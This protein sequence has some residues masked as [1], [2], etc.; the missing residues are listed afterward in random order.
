[1]NTQRMVTISEF[2][3]VIG[4][5]AF[6]SKDF[7]EQGIP[8]IKIKN[9]GNKKL[10]FENTDFLP[11]EFFETPNKF[12]IRYGDVLISLTGSHITQPNSAVGRVARSYSDKV[13]LLNQRVGKMK[14]DPDKC[15]LGFLYYYMTSTIFRDQVG[16]RSRGAANQANVSGGDIEGIKIPDYPLPTQQ[17]IARIL[18]TYDDLIENNLKRIKL[19]DEIAQITYEQWFVRMKFPG[20][21]TTLRD[22]EMGLPEGWSHLSI[23]SLLEHEIG[24][25]WG[26]DELSQDFSESA[27]V[28]RGTDFDSLTTGD[29]SDV[30][31][32]FH[33][34]SNLAS[35]KLKH[36]DIIFEVSGGSHYAGVART[37]FVDGELLEQLKD[38]VMCASFCKL[39]RTNR[40]SNAYLLYHFFKFLRSIKATEVFEIRSAS[41]IVN[42]HR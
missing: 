23:G 24:G 38:N 32:R 37:V 17:K 33:K 27:F 18:S 2:A 28:I 25:G 26:K 13:F 36:G 5:Y 12:K 29:L 15:D 9:I 30:P 8:V 40:L 16:L 7:V 31:Y 14:V 21:E 41:N 39:V 4:G 3:K 20:H 22:A 11:N 34:K 10:S 1:M 19:L 35:R 6:K 42:Y